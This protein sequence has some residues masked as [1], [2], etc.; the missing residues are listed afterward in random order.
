MVGWRLFLLIEVA[1]RSAVPRGGAPGRGA[2]AVPSVA[3]PR[4]VAMTSKEV[5]ILQRV[6]SDCMAPRCGDPSS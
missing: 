5:S 3:D 2:S 4:R 1:A 6:L